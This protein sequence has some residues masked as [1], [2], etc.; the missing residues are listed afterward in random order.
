MVAHKKGANSTRVRLF[1]CS[2]SVQTLPTR[3]FP[4]MSTSPPTLAVSLKLPLLLLSPPPP[5][6]TPSPLSL[7]MKTYTTATQTVY[8]VHYWLLPYHAETLPS[9]ALL[10]MNCAGAAAVVYTLRS[11][12]R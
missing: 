8:T 9:N 1:T 2:E 3:A 10:T 11:G 5:S 6:T 4:L 7:Q 12:C